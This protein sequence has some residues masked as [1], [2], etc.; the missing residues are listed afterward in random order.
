MIVLAHL[1]VLFSFAGA[2]ADEITSG[3]PPGAHAAAVGPGWNAGP[4]DDV[5]GGSPT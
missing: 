4:V 5:G 3:G 1:S 2:T